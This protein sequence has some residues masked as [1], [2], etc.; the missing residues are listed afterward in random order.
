V[1]ILGDGQKASFW[2][3]SW[4]HGQAPMD[5]FPDLFKLAW[6]KNKTVKEE[7]HN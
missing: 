6:R 7:L 2:Q 5:I 3:S 4:L 1:V